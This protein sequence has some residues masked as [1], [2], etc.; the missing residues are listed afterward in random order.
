MEREQWKET[1][2]ESIK[3]KKRDWKKKW[4]C[5]WREGGGSRV[6]RK[7]IAWPE[8]ACHQLVFR[9]MERA[10][11]DQLI[12]ANKMSFKTTILEIHHN[13]GADQAECICNNIY[14]NQYLKSTQ[15]NIFKP[16]NCQGAWWWISCRWCTHLRN[17]GHVRLYVC[18]FFFPPAFWSNFF[19]FSSLSRLEFM[20]LVSTL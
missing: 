12:R 17:R 2:N 18:F 7:D 11:S 10:K 4:K 19:F 13:L 16:I 15:W 1:K 9:T 6:K 20:A 5:T 8:A 14:L 3:D